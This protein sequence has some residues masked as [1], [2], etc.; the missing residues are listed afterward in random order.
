MA[1]DKLNFVF[2]GDLSFFYDM[3]ALWNPH[4]GKNLRILLLNN[5]GGEIFNALPG[6]R[7]T[8]ENRRYVLGTHQT[9]AQGWAVDSGFEYLSAHNA[10]ELATLLPRF[11]AADTTRPMLLEVFTDKDQDVQ[12]LRKYYHSIRGR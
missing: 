8:D 2:I 6:L 4:C 5:G 10:G 1:S 3:N 12:L 9:S 7:L 11:T